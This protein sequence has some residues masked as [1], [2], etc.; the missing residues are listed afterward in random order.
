MTR[1]EL[2]QLFFQA[3][4]KKLEFYERKIVMFWEWS[5]NNQPVFTEKSGQMRVGEHFCKVILQQ[6]YRRGKCLVLAN[7]RVTAGWISWPAGL[8]LLQSTASRQSSP[9][10]KRQ[11]TSFFGHFIDSFQYPDTNNHL[12]AHQDHIECFLLCTYAEVQLKIFLSPHFNNFPLL[13]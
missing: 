1:A 2:T 7:C 3:L 6:R 11:S 4:R 10:K 12:F 13:K 9:P 8:F 5:C